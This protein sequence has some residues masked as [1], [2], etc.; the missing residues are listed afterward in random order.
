MTETKE[1]IKMSGSGVSGC[2]RPLRE[3]RHFKM[4]KTLAQ[5]LI[6]GRVK[7]ILG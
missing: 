6:G 1:L 5:R 2:S 3:G 4:V 7:A